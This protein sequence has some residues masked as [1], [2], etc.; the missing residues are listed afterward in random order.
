MLGSQP[1]HFSTNAVALVSLS[2][3]TPS[4]APSLADSS[5]TALRP[6]AHLLFHLFIFTTVL[7][8]FIFCSIV[9]LMFLVESI[10]YYY[11]LFTSLKTEF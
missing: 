2:C 1:V 7:V 3:R 11:K 8:F 10:Y 9:L 6:L 4:L 5:S